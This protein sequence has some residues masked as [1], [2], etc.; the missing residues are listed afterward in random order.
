MAKLPFRV[1]SPASAGIVRMPNGQFASEMGPTPAEIVEKAE[2]Q[3]KSLDEVVVEQRKPTW[4]GSIPWPEAQ[5]TPRG[6]RV[7]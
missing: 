3:K 6:F 2:S 5:Q 4:S 1:T 7:R